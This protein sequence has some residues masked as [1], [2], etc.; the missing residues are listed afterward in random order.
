MV[1]LL[2][3]IYERK[4]MRAV[5]IQLGAEDQREDTRWYC[6]LLSRSFE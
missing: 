5:Y 6:S 3:I 1:A 2:F 4:A